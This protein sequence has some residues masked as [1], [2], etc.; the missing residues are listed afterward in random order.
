MWLQLNLISSPASSQESHL[1]TLNLWL[2][3]FNVLYVLRFTESVHKHISI[4]FNLNWMCN[5]FNLMPECTCTVDINDGCREYTFKL[6]LVTLNKKKKRMY[7]LFTINHM[8]VCALFKSMDTCE[9]RSGCSHRAE[10]PGMC[11]SNPTEVQKCFSRSHLV[12]MNRPRV[13]CSHWKPR[14]WIKNPWSLF[15]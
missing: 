4:T 1:Y 2:T 12:H 5:V 11:C 8:C 3:C 7:F 6:F 14:N 13:Q 15:G 9:W 10:G